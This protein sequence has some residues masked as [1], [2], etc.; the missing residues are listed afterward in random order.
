MSENVQYDVL[1]VS[2]TRWCGLYAAM[3]CVNLVCLHAYMCYCLSALD[4]NDPECTEEGE[5][6]EYQ[7]EGDQGQA[8][9]GKPSKL[10]SYL[11]LVLLIACFINVYETT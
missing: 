5:I 6:F 3:M 8:E 2:D 1:I 11:I 7:E 10:D 9:K 4:S